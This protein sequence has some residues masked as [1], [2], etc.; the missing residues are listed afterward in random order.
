M[1]VA[2]ATQ[3][4]RFRILET[5]GKG[6]FGTVYRAEMTDSGGFSKQVA[7]KVMHYDGQQVD[8][9]ARRLRDEA[10]MLGLIRHRAVVGVNSLVPLQDG[11][12]VVME[13]IAGVDLSTAIKKDRPN[14]GVSLEIVEEVAA[15]LDSA[16]NRSL[17]PDGSPLRLIHR[18][19]KPAN[20]RITRQGE[21]KLLDF[22]VAT[23]EL[24]TREATDGRGLLIGSSRY[25]SPERHKGEETHAADVFALGVVL[26][27]LLTGKR[28]KDPPQDQSRHSRWLGTVLETVRK[29]MET[30]EDPEVRAAAARVRLLLLEMLAFDRHDRPDAHGVELRCRK[31]RKSLPPPWMRDWAER[32]VP[33]LASQPEPATEGVEGDTGLVFEELMSEVLDAPGDTLASRTGGLATRRRIELA[34]AGTVGFLAGS[35]VTWLLGG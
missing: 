21:V 8:E 23:A 30:S 18:D 14:E 16:F 9:I 32:T 35:A 4:R 3:R 27:N 17:G 1:T 6:G 15:A 12:G 5:L 31:I 26:A 10:R 11:W 2:A 25:M 28:F 33:R 19:I 24:E 20:I 13:Y 29:R 22:G 34:A 7:L